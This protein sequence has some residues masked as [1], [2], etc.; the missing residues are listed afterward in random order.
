MK[1]HVRHCAKFIKINNA[2]TKS[3]LITVVRVQK[4]SEKE[5]INP[6]YHVQCLFLIKEFF[7]AVHKGPITCTELGLV[8]VMATIALILP[9]SSASSPASAASPSSLSM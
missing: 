6:K 7:H 9:A 8:L 2:T 1:I 4:V 5:F 3:Q